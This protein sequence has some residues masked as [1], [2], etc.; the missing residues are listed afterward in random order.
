MTLTGIEPA[1]GRRSLLTVLKPLVG[2]PVNAVLTVIILW[3]LVT[4]VPVLFRWAVI[5]AIWRVDEPPERGAGKLEGGK[6]DPTIGQI[7]SLDGI[8]R[9]AGDGQ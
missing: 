4:T 2:T 7:E 9:L 6:I 1:G 8:E 5:D 3:L